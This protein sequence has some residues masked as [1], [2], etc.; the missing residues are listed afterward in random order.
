[1]DDGDDLNYQPRWMGMIGRMYIAGLGRTYEGYRN[2]QHLPIVPGFVVTKLE[3]HAMEFTSRREAFSL[4][5]SIGGEV[6]RTN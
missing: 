6:I 4:A 2:S 3:N 5:K 1:M